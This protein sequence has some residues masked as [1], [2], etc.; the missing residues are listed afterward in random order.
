MIMGMAEVDRSCSPGMPAAVRHLPHS[1]GVYRFV[2]AKGRVLYI[3][4]ALD[5]RQRVASYWGGLGD[6]RHLQ[7]MV[8]RAQTVQA[9]VCASGHEAAWLER[10]LLEAYKPRA[11]RARGGQEVPTLIALAVAGAAPRLK[12]VHSP[13]LGAWRHFGPYLGGD[14]ARLAL[15]GLQRAYSLAYL[16]ER[17]TG[18]ERDMARGVSSATGAELRQAVCAVLDREPAAVADL[19]SALK[20]HRDRA[21]AALAFELAGRV[22]DEIDAIGWLSSPQR[23]TTL[24]PRDLDVYGWHDGL[25]VHFSVRAGRLSNWRQRAAGALQAKRLTSETPAIWAEFAQQNAALAA[26][27]VQATAS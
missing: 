6:R 13:L 24:E 17:L 7:G 14:Q 2:D 9:V 15:S 21:A 16:G 26:R 8:S 5:L 25:L 20:G 10:N 18:S 22:Q 4:R 3:G 12:A 27:L 1:P 11:N 23:V 19:Q